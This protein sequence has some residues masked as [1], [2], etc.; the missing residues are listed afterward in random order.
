MKKLFICLIAGLTCFAVISFTPSP[1]AADSSN[2]DETDLGPLQV[3]PIAVHLDTVDDMFFSSDEV[4]LLQGSHEPPGGFGWLSWNGDQSASWLYEEL[5]NPR[6][7]ATHFINAIDFTDTVLDVCDWISSLAGATNSSDVRKAM[8]ALKGKTILLP[9]Y[10]CVA[11]E[12]KNGR[13]HVDSFARVRIG[14][15][16]LPQGQHKGFING[17]LIEWLGDDACPEWQCE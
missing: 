13:Y 12:G 17:T 14:D 1:T 16:E 5:N 10:D 15:S 3:L 4:D 6:L 2:D 7:S 11:G 9:V 8:K